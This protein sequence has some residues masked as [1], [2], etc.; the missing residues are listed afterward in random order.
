ML[1]LTQSQVARIRSGS[2]GDAR[3]EGRQS[4]PTDTVGDL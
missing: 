4:T 2:S 3:Q 1:E